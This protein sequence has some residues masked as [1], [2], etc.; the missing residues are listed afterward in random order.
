MAKK[1]AKKPRTF[2]WLGEE[3][4]FTEETNGDDLICIKHR[5]T[6]WRSVYKGTT[7]WCAFYNHRKSLNADAAQVEV[8]GPKRR[9]EQAALN[10]LQTY[11]L[12]A[13]KPFLRYSEDFPDG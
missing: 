4:V 8:E 10:A 6:L 7:R 12:S 11:A 5:L 1:A 13:L 9:S 2:E 3:V